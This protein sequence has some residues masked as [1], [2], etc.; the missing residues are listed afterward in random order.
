[1]RTMLG[2]LTFQEA[3][4]RT[5]RILNIHVSSASLY[6]LPKL[7]NYITSPTVIIWS[8]VAASCS[9]PLIFTSASLLAKDPRTGEATPWN[10]STIKWIDGSV[11]SDIPMARVAEMFNV[12]HFIVSQV[13]PHVIPFL[14]EGQEIISEDEAAENSNGWFQ[15]LANLAKDEVMH[16]MHV[17]SELGVFPNLFTK[18]RSVLNQKYSGDI[19]IF[20]EIPYSSFPQALA[21]PSTDFMLGASLCGERATWPKMGMIQNHCAVELALDDAVQHLRARI[22]FSPS[23]VNLRMN[24]ISRPVSRAGSDTNGSKTNGRHRKKKRA[25]TVDLERSIH[26]VLFEPHA[27]PLTLSPPP[28]YKDNSAFTFS[29]ILASRL[30]AS[31]YAVYG[32]NGVSSHNTYGIPP[33]LS[34]YRTENQA[35]REIAD[36][37]EM[38]EIDNDDYE[39]DCFSISAASTFPRRT[40]RRLFESASQPSTPYTRTAWHASSYFPPS[41]PDPISPLASRKSSFN[42][43]QP[44]T[45]YV[46]DLKV[47]DPLR[48]TENATMGYRTPPSPTHSK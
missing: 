25:D 37:T 9:V 39:D 3:Y 30:P 7:L 27:M 28:P 18:T 1:M 13:N 26:D 32:T 21:N 48:R 14:R 44:P 45:R 47:L 46:P 29:D 12:N 31:D 17:M 20:P 43:S 34:P 23:Q 11:E 22:A 16:R 41:I 6:E 15:T 38:E 42:S 8:A 10:P 35:D 33:T 24:V 40:N 19:N 36:N 4:N 5:R 2:D